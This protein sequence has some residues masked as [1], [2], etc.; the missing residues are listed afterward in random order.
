MDKSA[1][2][3]KRAAESAVDYVKSGMRLGLGTGSTVRFALEAISQRLKTGVLQDIVGVATSLQTERIAGELSIPLTTLVETPQLDLAID[4]ADEVDPGLNLIKGGGGALL[5]EKVVAQAS[6]TFLVIV[7]E[8]K[9]SPQLGTNWAVPIEIMPFALG[10]VQR[11]LSEMGADPKI[12]EGSDRQPMMTD[13][14]NLIIDADFKTIADPKALSDALDR[15]AG[16]MEHGLFVNMATSVLCASAK[17]VKV[18][19]K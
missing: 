10:H 1:S 6:E 4:G 7:D 5:R 14:Q 9:L 13:Q 12:R 15:I 17:G 11:V 8:Q 16:I 3:K 18:I 19:E 2:L